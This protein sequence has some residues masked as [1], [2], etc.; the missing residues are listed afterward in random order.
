M[1]K[2]L[3]PINPSNLTLLQTA[4]DRSQ[5]G[6]TM[7]PRFFLTGLQAEMYIEREDIGVGI[8]VFTWIVPFYAADNK[9]ITRKLQIFQ[10]TKHPAYTS[11][12]PDRSKKDVS[13]PSVPVI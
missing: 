1:K 6:V 13:E 4:A 8:P 5:D 9:T 10:V 3:T 7:K 2:T 11:L 12:P